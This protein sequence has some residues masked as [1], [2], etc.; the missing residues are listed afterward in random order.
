M[1]AE[2][3]HFAL[4]LALVVSAAGA[5]LPLAGAAL[6]VFVHEPL[7]E[8]RRTVGNDAKVCHDASH[9]LESGLAQRFIKHDGSGVGE[10]ERADAV[11]LR[12]H[13]VAADVLGE[14]CGVFVLLVGA[15]A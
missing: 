13:E 4:I 11:V 9:S 1:T 10:V 7:D 15:P 6:D 3:G 5:V 8:L 14:K 12:V 2:I